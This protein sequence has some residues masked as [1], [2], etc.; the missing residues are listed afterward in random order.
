MSLIDEFE[1]KPEVKTLLQKKGELEEKERQTLLQ[2]LSVR[3]RLLYKKEKKKIPIT[4]DEDELG[5]IVVESRVLESKELINLMDILSKG[6]E[7]DLTE[8]KENYDQI[9]EIIGNAICDPD[10]NADF[11]KSQVGYTFGDLL[12]IARGLIEG[13][14]RSNKLVEEE[15]KRFRKI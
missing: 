4:I 9:S 15:I 8:F 7:T 13:S 14:I 5:P 2:N 10:L 6:E 3:Q 1:Q 12:S 11:F